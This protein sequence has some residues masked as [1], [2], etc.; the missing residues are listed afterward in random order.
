MN[1]LNVQ[2]RVS[3]QIAMTPQLL[4][5]IRLLQL[6]TLE[7]EQE[8]R[9]ALE[10][11]VML[12]GPD[13]DMNAIDVDEQDAADE[14]QDVEVSGVD[15]AAEGRVEADFDWSS[16]DSWSGGE[17]PADADGESWEARI[18]AA[19]PTDARLAALEQL[20]LVVRN[21]REAALCEAIID[22]V[23]DNGYLSQPLD[24][25]A[26][27]S[28][29]QPTPDDAEMRA[30]LA[31]VQTV[32]PTGFAARD[33]RECLQLQIAATPADASGRALA[34]TL[35]ADHLD[36]LADRDYAALAASL[37]V[38]ALQLHAALDLILSLNP[39]PASAL[40]AGA[41]AALPDLIVS[42]TPGSWRVELNAERLPRVRV[43]SRYERMLGS[44][45]HRAMRDQ[46][47]EAR[48][49]VRGLEMRHDT[50]LRTGRAIFQRQQAFLEKGEEGMVSLTLREIAD[51]I[52]MHESTVC[53]VT[54]NK[55]VATPWGVYELKAFFP[56]QIAGRGLESSG[57]A[58]KAMIRRI[59]NA[60][61]RATPLSDGQITALLA[62]QGVEVARRTVAKYREAMRIP[63]VKE[64]LPRDVGRHLT[65]AG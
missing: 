20:Q 43:N 50:L 44:T 64:R 47:Q 3:Q 25:I 30:V 2:P 65:M 48:W 60:E 23:D 21:A 16:R 31:L 35:V 56:S 62:R 39:K 15:A 29:L 63:P 42:G 7:L 54:S 27:Q 33:L 6:S 11:N 58:V 37:G 52:G 19:T 26:L 32:E 13:D 22:A 9:Q 12:E 57:T 61:N 24:G 8:L 46:L 41:E 10:Q 53:R 4:Q 40:A 28:A 55:W 18:G 17:P 45:A 34:Q 51:S 5:S 36:A 14:R 59:I 49:L 1:K 38:D